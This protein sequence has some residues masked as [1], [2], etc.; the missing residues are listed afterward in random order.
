M[1]HAANDIWLI[2]LNYLCVN[3]HVL[4]ELP[5]E[6][7]ISFKRSDWIEFRQWVHRPILLK[8]KRKATRKPRSSTSFKNNLY[9]FRL[10]DLDW[11]CSY[12]PATSE[13]SR[14][15][16]GCTKRDRSW[17]HPSK[18]DFKKSNVFCAS[19]FLVEFQGSNYSRR[20]FKMIASLATQVHIFLVDKEE[21]IGRLEENR[22]KQQLL[23]A[24]NK[25]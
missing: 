12:I 23:S 1:L 22:K 24:W 15:G 11:E 21:R 3:T 19:C 13:L 5:H 7:A 17:Q 16:N 6:S 4:V 2:R 10:H 14:T 20:I 25:K 9:F 18:L 8:G